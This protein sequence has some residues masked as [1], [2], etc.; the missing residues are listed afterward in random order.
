MKDQKDEKSNEFKTL[1][2]EMGVT[3]LTAKKLRVRTTTKHPI[4]EDA[5][6]QERPC[7][8]GTIGRKK[9][10][11]HAPSKY[12]L[13]HQVSREETISYS[14]TPHDK[15]LLNAAADGK[16]SPFSTLDLHGMTL[17]EAEVAL[18]QF[19]KTAQKKDWYLV[20]II[21]GKGGRDIENYPVL[22]N[23][24]YRWLKSMPIVGGLCSPPAKYG[25]SG[26]VYVVLNF[27]DSAQ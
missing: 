26:A 6:F 8:T 18:S 7:A 16:I 12:L 25:G 23:Y 13:H 5:K 3:P 27:D 22:K 21:H 19:L 24:V 11:H 20:K 9:T 2:E 17:P 15:Q 1:M 4:Q 10:A 14:R